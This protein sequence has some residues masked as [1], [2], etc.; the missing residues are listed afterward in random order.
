MRPLLMRFVDDRSGATAI[1]YALI[2]AGIAMVMIAALQALGVTT[3]TSDA[4]K[5]NRASANSTAS[6]TPTTRINKRDSRPDRSPIPFEAISL[7]FLMGSGLGDLRSFKLKLSGTVVLQDA[8]R[9]SA[10]RQAPYRAG[11]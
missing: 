2:A 7:S 3:A 1:E 5:R 4:G 9:G 11:V 6:D 10:A 8:A